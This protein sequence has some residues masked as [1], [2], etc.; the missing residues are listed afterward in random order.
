MYVSLSISTGTTDPSQCPGKQF[1]Y[2]E[3]RLVLGTILRRYDLAEAPGFNSHDFERSFVDRAIV[4]IPTA[5]R[6]VLTKR[7]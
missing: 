7:K 2:Q 4:D 3:M 1:A 5:L 6:V